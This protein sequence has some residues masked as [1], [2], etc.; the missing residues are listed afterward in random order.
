MLLPIICFVL[1]T[2]KHCGREQGFR[3]IRCLLI[4]FDATS[5]GHSCHHFK[6]NQFA[7]HQQVALGLLSGDIATC[8]DSAKLA[9]PAIQRAWL[10]P[11]S[12]S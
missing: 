4:P 9:T 3:A 12:L 2:E 6:M 5:A 7:L 11:F 10:S 1:S 8:I